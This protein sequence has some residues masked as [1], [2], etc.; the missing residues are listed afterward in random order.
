[1]SA[2]QGEDVT[3]CHQKYF[4]F[5]VKDMQQTLLEVQMKKKSPKLQIKLLTLPLV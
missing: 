1:M 2:C 4:L 3:P 5:F